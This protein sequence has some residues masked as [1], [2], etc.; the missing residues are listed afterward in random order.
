[1]RRYLV[2][3]PLN[4][5]P[6]QQFDVVIAGAGMA[7]LYTALSLDSHI[8]C[9]I[10]IKG[11]VNSG[12][13]WLAQ[14]G[15]AAAVNSDDHYSYH[16]SD[17][18]KASAGIS[19]LEA[20]EAMVKGGPTE[21][22]R[23]AALGVEFDRDE[24]G[25]WHTTIEGA[26]SKKRILHCGGDAT[27]KI[28]M[29][30]LTTLAKSRQ[31]IIFLEEHF[32]T[33]I[34]TDEEQSVC[35]AVAWHEGFKFLKAP[36]VVISTGGIGAIYRYSTN[37]MSSSGD[38]IATAIRAGAEL[39]DMEFV[40]FHPTAFY[41][42]GKTQSLQLISEAVRGEGGILRNKD[43]VAFMKGRHPLR[44]L[45][46][47][48]VVAREMFYEL[49][50]TGS[51]NLYLDITS[52]SGEFLRQRFPTIYSFCAKEGIFMEHDMIPVVPVQHY[53]MGGISTNL[54]G[55][56]TISG[57]YACGEAACTGVHGA[58]RLASNSLLECLVFGARAARAINV[59]APITHAALPEI[60]KSDDVE[61][62]PAN[63]REEI[64][65]LMQNSGGIIREGMEMDLALNRITHILN[66]FENSIPTLPG[67][68]EIY[69]MA[70]VAAGI[71]SAA[72][73]R[74]EGIGSHY[75]IDKAIAA[76]DVNDSGFSGCL[77]A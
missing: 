45:A 24:F 12:N 34:I 48:D 2:N 35:G 26:H 46:P 76:L 6:Q 19:D 49:Q 41:Q 8:R 28:V 31:N 51:T 66:K 65:L 27:G 29:H 47:R 70:L 23:L 11:K 63:E 22:E 37:C 1:M 10:L 54:N 56:T 57:L 42:S 73:R 52:R 17:T 61:F 20:L 55:Q 13:S 30:S 4:Q 9:A 16:F 75:R 38:G 18:L 40:Q 43:G 14:G 59:F 68:F 7:G 62:V 53:L 39:K 58:N 44:D 15:I 72:L 64:T 3:Q 67:H 36:V 60:P 33:D 50:R 32:L 5:L 21:I 25:R 77:D 74:E 71:L 69:N